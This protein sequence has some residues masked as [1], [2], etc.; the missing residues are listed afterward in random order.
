MKNQLRLSILISFTMVFFH[1]SDTIYAQTWEPTN[2]PYG[3]SI[4]CLANND[5]ILFAGTGLG[6]YGNGAFK[7]S[8]NGATWSVIDGIPSLNSLA[9]IGSTLIVSS[10]GIYQSP[11]NGATW[12]SS[13]YSPQLSSPNVIITDGVTTFAGGFSGFYVSEDSGLTW[14]SRNDNNFPGITL[15]NL[16]DIKAMAFCGSYLYAG[17]GQK[18]IFRSA[19]NGLTWEAV[20]SGLGNISSRTFGSFA[21]IGTDIFVGTIGQGVFRLVNNGN[22]WTA[23][24]NGLPTGAAQRVR[25]MIIKDSDIYVGTNAG[26]YRSNNTGTINWMQTGGNMTGQQFHHLLLVGSDIYSGVSNKGIY[27]SS[28]NSNTWASVNQGITGVSTRNLTHGLNSDILA[29][30]YEGAIYTSSDEGDTWVTGNISADAGPCLHGTS[31]FVGTE[32]SCYRSTDYGITWNALPGFSDVIWGAAYTFLSIGDTLFAGCGAE[33]G[34]YYSTDNGDS[35]NVTS[36]IWNLNPW[37][38]YPGVLS[39]LENG[40]TMY[41]GTVNGV[42]KSS[43][44]G[45]NWVTCYPAMANIPISSFAVSG[46]Y[47]FAGTANYF[48]DPNLTPLGIYRSGDNG[49]TWVPVNTGLG[50]FDVYSLTVN[51]TDLFAGTTSGIYKSTNNG[52]SWVAINDGYPNPPFAKSLLVEGNY[53]YSG[54]FLVGQPVYRRALS[55]SAPDMPGAING[56]ATPCIGSTQTYSVDNVSGVTYTWQVPSDWLITNGQGTNEV[57]V[58]TGNMTGTI[59]VIPSNGWG[60]GP[61]QAMAVIPV[62]IVPADVM[63]EADNNQICAGTSVTYTT[64]AV[65]AGDTPDY[66]WYVNNIES[67]SNSPDFT[68]IPVNGDI[69]GVQLT[70]SL[71]CVTNNP[72]QSN[73]IQMEVTTPTETVSVILS[74]DQVNVCAGTPVTFTAAPLSGGANPVYQWYVNGTATGTNSPEYTYIPSNNDEVYVELIS[75][76]ECVMNNPAF[77]ETIQMEVTNPAD[78]VSVNIV[79]GQNTV[80][81]GSSALFIAT[82]L[83]GG[84]APSYQWFVNETAAGTNSPEFSFDPSNNDEVYVIVTSSL[85]CVSNNPAQSNTLVVEVTDPVEVTAA[86][87]VDQNNVCAGTPVVFTATMVNGGDSPDYLWFVNGEVTGTNSPEFSYAPSNGDEVYVL[88]ASSLDCVIE[89]QVTSN[90]I[91]LQVTEPVEVSATI[92]VDQNNVCEGTQSTFTA[93]PV[94]GGDSPVYQWFVNG[95]PSG[96]SETYSYIPA[97]GDLVYVVMTSSLGCTTNNQAISNIIQMQVST[98]VEVTNTITVQQNNLCDGSEFSFTASTTGGGSQPDY[99]W[100]VNGSPAGENTLNFAYVA[101][102][103]DV[104]SMVF[105]SSEMCTTENPVTSNTITAVV[106]PLPEVSWPGFEPDTLCIEDWEPVTLTGGTP[107]GG[108]YS[109]NGVDNNIFD[110]A[111]AGAGTHEITYTYSN[112]FGCTSQSSLFLFVDVCLGIS[113]NGAGLLVYPNPASDNLMVKMQDNSVMQQ[114]TLTNL[115]GIQVYQNENPDT[116]ETVSIPVQNLPSGNYLLRIISNNKPIFKTVI[117]N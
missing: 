60:D 76:L 55:G 81:T 15:P 86:I 11:D 116:H 104:V 36:G 52:D 68:Y 23:E 40:S 93:T 16:P 37:G 95:N 89:G 46:D 26:L 110:P 90:T 27:V 17:T 87:T 112:S 71:E 8:N 7:S 42:F 56:S 113:E 88:A 114:I 13:N 59:I 14:T 65:N 3:G 105:T 9:S 49:V 82:P 98:I 31:L 38:G 57:I 50:N 101:E 80:C 29:S 25:T 19:D 72:A 108:T 44:N 67:G 103:A 84:N 6:I 20:N 5:N 62:A 79:L 96:S 53:L 115:L 33:Y 4:T 28:D 111:Q 32:G 64:T 92:E 24:N 35:W 109:G 102:N 22:T 99:Q 77:S 117:I 83:N 107:E 51:G 94:N 34:V 43:D 18:G 39:L 45:L 97:N 47:I 21:V 48:E 70:S 78:A 61:A 30:T 75:S 2:G 54:N 91:V 66:Q 41:A 63:I 100:M 1:F 69:V 10:N 106:N 74:V 73:T 58:T 85:D 12:Q